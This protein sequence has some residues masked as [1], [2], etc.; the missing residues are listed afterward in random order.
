MTFLIKLALLA[1]LLYLILVAF[2]HSTLITLNLLLH[3][4][5]LLF[6]ARLIFYRLGLLTVCLVGSLFK[7]KFFSTC[8]L[9][10]VI[11]IIIW[12]RLLLVGESVVKWWSLC[13]K[14]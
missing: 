4:S 12:L 6:F 13:F 8:L 5:I 14:V 1:L 7:C 3:Y 9:Q 2:T 10:L 11:V